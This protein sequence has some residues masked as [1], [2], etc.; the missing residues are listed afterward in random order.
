VKDSPLI[1][2]SEFLGKRHLL[3]KLLTPLL[4]RPIERL[5]KFNQLNDV[6]EGIK[7]REKFSPETNFFDLALAE[8]GTDV[9]IQSGSLESIPQSGPVFVV[10]NHPFGAVDGLILGSLLMA[11]RKDTKLLAN[12]LLGRMPQIRANL[13]PVSPFGTRKAIKQNL[14]G[15]R[16]AGKWLAE[17]HCVATFPAGYVSNFNPERKEV[18]DSDWHTNVARLARKFQATVV[19]IRFEGSNSTLFQSLGRLHPKLRMLALVREV[20]NP[21]RSKVHVRIGSP[22]EP[23]KFTEFKNDEALVRYFRMRSEVL[24]HKRPPQSLPEPKGETIIER[25]PVEKL[26][27]E[28]ETL[29]D[30]CLLCKQGVFHVYTATAP[31]IPA[32]LE[33]IGRTREVTF[34]SVGE[35]VGKA[36]DIDRFDQTYH[37]LFLWNNETCEIVGAYRIGLV[38][39][40]IAEHGFDGLYSNKVIEYSE[41]AFDS[42]GPGG[43]LELGRSYIVPKYQKRGTSLFLLWRGIVKFV[44][45]HPGYTKLFGTVSISDRYSPMSQ[46]LLISYMKKHGQAAAFENKIRARKRSRFEHVRGL[47]AFEYPGALPSADKVGS[48]ISEMEPDQKGFPVLLKH[49]LQ[50]NGVILGVGVDQNF[51]DVLDGFILVDLEKIDPAVLGKYEGR[52]K[53]P[54]T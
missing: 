48:L 10:S 16:S 32:I 26:I 42:L 5:L 11:R 43:I 39:E 28:I 35:G 27:A 37:H 30:D 36:L 52:P 4:I 53:T 46:A 49:Y 22:I 31:Q 17:G 7:V 50:L 21:A 33:E 51:G 9:S 40:I 8:L 19:P 13:I 44:R 24:R 29:P 12:S 1:D 41:D 47:E 54:N 15:L 14:A 3:R 2:L 20:F 38:N 18:T 45:K 23:H 34:R 25:Q 6:Y